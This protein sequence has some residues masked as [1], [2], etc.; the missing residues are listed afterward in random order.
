V[1]ALDA[2]DPDVAMDL[3]RA[4][5]MPNLGRMLA[6][7]ARSTVRNPYGLFVGAVWPSFATG[8]G[9]ARH[10]VHCWETIDLD[11]YERRTNPQPPEWGTTFWD[12]A[13]DADR[14]VAILD[15]PHTSSSREVNGV[16][17]SE[18]GCHDR[19][20]GLRSAPPGFADE[21]LRSPGPHPILGVDARRVHDFAPDDYVLREGRLRSTDEEVALTGGLLTGVDAKVELST[22]VLA[23]EPWDLF[24]TVFGESHAVGHQQWHLHDAD[25]PRFDP[26]AQ[27][28]VGG[29]PLAQVYAALDTALGKLLLQLDDDTTL[30]VLLSHGMGPH[31]DGTHLLDQVLHRIDHVERGGGT[32][33]LP[34]ALAKR[35][36]G[37]LP[38]QVRW[39]ASSVAAPLLRASAA[40]RR[41]AACDE[42]IPAAERALQEAYLSPNNFVVA[43]VRLNLVGREPRGCVQP[44]EVPGLV[45]RLRGDLSDLVNVDTG[46]RVV[47]DVQPATRWYPDGLVATM[48][49]LFVTWER[50]AVVETVWSPKVG[51]VHA[52]YTHW[53][54]GDHRHDGLLLAS[55]PGI[56]P[57]PRPEVRNVDLGPSI[58]ARLGLGTAPS[59][60][61]DGDPVGWLAPD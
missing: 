3:V 58:L 54:T 46:G 50:T 61:L 6:R 49:D 15:V 8:N 29:D 16:Q 30:L 23:Q 39:K 59:A 14:R 22:A 17:I 40:R 41:P 11:T 2:C 19:H 45:E 57:G 52:P 10:G 9:P 48:P 4:G 38:A 5:R 25:H 13:G 20:F 7:S 34:V 18:W 33:P 1:V 53:R 35:A 32:G 21:V 36:A 26:A 31:Y 28:A 27:A 42:F 43:G 37:A 55:G 56:D 60:D 12:L 44:Y 24:V 47:L 51:L